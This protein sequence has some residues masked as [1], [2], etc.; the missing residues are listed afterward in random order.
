MNLST[1]NTN[2]SKEDIDNV[3]QECEKYREQ[4]IQ[5]CLQYFGCEYAYAEDCVQEAYVSLYESLKKGIEIKNYKSWL[6]AVSL[7]QKNKVI[8]NKN[9]FKEVDFQ[10]NEEK[11]FTINN[12][13]YYNPDYTDD[14]IE[15]EQI[16]NVVVQILSELTTE[17]KKLY[18]L[19]YQKGMK[20]KDIS[21]KLDVKYAT[22]RKR[23]EKLKKKL[24]KLIKKYGF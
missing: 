10:N 8:K 13:L 22:I 5:Y 20:L 19:Y 17:E 12:S 23:H 6:Y 2:N 14:M 15:D 9:K 1:K 4:L 24:N 3:I 11:D 7:Y 21:K 16:N 18:L